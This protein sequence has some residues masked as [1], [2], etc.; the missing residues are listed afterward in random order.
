MAQKSRLLGQDV[1][2]RLTLGG[3]P[4]TTVTAVKNFVFETRQR[5]LTEQYLG[6]TQNRQDSIFDE[7]GG[8]FVVHPEDPEIL[9]F[10]KALAD[11]AIA[12]SANE[13]QVSI[14]FRVTFPSKKVAKIVIPE[15]EFDPVPFNVGGRDAYVDMTFTY[16]A[17]KYT[18]TV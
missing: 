17:E 5:I 8:S 13:Q 10:Q 14:S 12:R 18:L 16:K 6:E 11:K 7:V 2:I 15:V 1:Q 3:T 9:K 4:L